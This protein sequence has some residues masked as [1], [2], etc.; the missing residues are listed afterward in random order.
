[1]V[2]AGCLEGELPRISGSGRFF[3][4]EQLR[5]IPV[6]MVAER[7]L[8]SLAEEERLFALARS[9]AT[10]RVVATA[11]PEPGL[12][13]SRLVGEWPQREPTLAFADAV[14]PPALAFADSDVAVWPDGKLH[15]S[16]TRLQTYEDCP[17]KFALTYGLR[18]RDGGNIWAGFGTLVHAILAEFLDPDR[19]GERTWD[20][21]LA[22]AE[23]HW[24]DDIARY[25][26]QREE[27][28]RDLFAL[29]ED[30]WAEEGEGPHAP[31]V[32]AVE[33]PFE[34][35]VG[36]HLVTG[37]IDRVD[38][39]DG[40]IGIVDYKTSRTPA[41]PEDVADDLQ[42]RTY[43][44]AAGR[45]PVLRALGP[46]V[47]LRLLYLRTMTTREQPVEEG[48]ADRTE[49]RIL[50]AAERILAEDFEPSVDADCDHCDFH[51]LC[52]LQPEGREVGAA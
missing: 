29:L 17:L 49:A 52:P 47:S 43:H 21:L 3:D 46:A 1:M 36:P 41:R 8:W 48:H 38:R 31:D 33:R 45:D 28:R 35:E 10:G 9:R 20:E 19:P 4:R 18:V 44:L 26:P 23:R 11:A 2:I 40:G 51:R 25:R 7:R 50:E 39:V 32:V 5:G 27:A 15:L 30:W 14:P 42:L 6:P 24:T 22:T 16:A 37:T 12:L 34:I 13:V